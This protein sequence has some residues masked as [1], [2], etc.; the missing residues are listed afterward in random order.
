M[1]E[2]SMKL[3]WISNQWEAIFQL[4]ISVLKQ[5]PM[6]AYCHNWFLNKLKTWKLFL[7]VQ[8]KEQYS[9][10]IKTLKD[11]TLLQW[12]S[13]R[14]FLNLVLLLFLDQLILK[15]NNSRMIEEIHLKLV[16]LVMQF[17]LLASQQFQK[18]DKLFMK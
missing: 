6:L 2:I 7:M 17:K 18:L 4:F 5:V 15:L 14:V 8:L 1:K 12:L 13:K 9:R 3:D 11:W 10:L 16:F